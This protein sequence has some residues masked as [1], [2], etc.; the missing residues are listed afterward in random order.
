MQDVDDLRAARN[1]NAAQMKGKL[2][3]TRRQE[4]VAEGK[5]LKDQLAG[6][7]EELARWEAYCHPNRKLI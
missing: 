5:R 3:Q 6:L 1:A 7:E 4:L 2:D